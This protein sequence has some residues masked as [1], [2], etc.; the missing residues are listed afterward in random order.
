[1]YGV[2]GCIT[3]WNYP[4]NLAFA[5][6]TAALAAGNVIVIKP[7][8]VTPGVGERIR[9]VLAPLPAGVAT[10]IQG[11][12]EVGAA[13]VNAPVDKISFIGSAR[14]GKKIAEAASA[15][16][17]PVVMEL[18]GIDA[19]I[20]CDDADLETASSGVLWGAFMNAGQTCCSIERVYVDEKVADEFSSLLLSKLKR[21][22]EGP[23][24]NLGPLTFG[25]QLET[26]KRH[27]DDAI[28]K[29]AEIL[30]GGPSDEEMPGRWYKPTVLTSITEE[31]DLSRE[32][33][34]GPVLPIIRVRDEEEAVRRTNEDGFNLTA[35]VWTKDN[36]RAKRIAGKLRAGTVCINDHGATEGIPWTPWGGAGE[37]G[38]GRLNGELGLKEF[39]V[40]VHIWKNITPR[41][42][43]LWWYPYDQASVQ[44]LRGLTEAASAP[45]LAE[46]VEGAK[47][48]AGNVAAALRRKL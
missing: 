4:F 41:L 40:P 5:S 33:T 7:T 32:E 36:S 31:M 14:T 24:E 37:S 30:A 10:V 42:R 13:L 17:T 34:F 3:A 35:S 22:D 26:V 28:N 47:K 11:G 8:E 9:E 27:V 46:K 19:A 15:H 1:P 39:S 23:D 44:T 12:S 43:R 2:V 25:P 38:Y 48:F 6:M 45:T 16:L 21:V 18:G 29:G 20:V